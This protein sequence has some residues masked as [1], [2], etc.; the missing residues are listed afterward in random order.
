MLAIHRINH[1]EKLNE[2]SHRPD[3][4]S[5]QEYAT[6]SAFGFNDN[7]LINLTL[8]F[9]HDAG[10]HLYETPINNSQAIEEIDDG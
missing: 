9:T 1:A 5:I 8:K 6:T 4:F 2:Q 10:Q 3:K 7:G